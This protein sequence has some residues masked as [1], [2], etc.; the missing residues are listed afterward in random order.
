MDPAVAAAIIKTGGDVLGGLFGGGGQQQPTMEDY[1]QWGEQ[2]GLSNMNQ[3]TA[4]SGGQ[5]GWGN[6]T[7]Y[8]NQQ[9]TNYQN[10]NQA[11]TGGGQNTGFANTLGLQSE[12]GY[13]NQQG[14]S[15]TGGTQ[16]QRGTG[17]QQYQLRGFDPAEQAAYG[18]MTQ[19]MSGLAG[20]LSPEAQAAYG[21]QITESQRQAGLDQVNQE[22]NRQGARQRMAMARTGTG[23]GSVAAEQAAQLAGQ[24]ALAGNQVEATA[25]AAGQNA[26]NQR[27]AA[28]QGA[29]GTMGNAMAGMQGSRQTLG[30]T[31]SFDTTGQSNQTTRNNQQN[32]FGN[33]V[34]N[35]QRTNTGQ[36]Y[37][38]YQNMNQGMQGGYQDFGQSGQQSNY[39]SDYFNNQNVNQQNTNQ[40]YNLFAQ[41]AAQGGYQPGFFD[42]RLAGMGDR[43]AN[44]A[45]PEYGQ[46]P[47]S[48][49]VPPNANY[50]NIP[51]GMTGGMTW[52]PQV[53]QQSPAA[54]Q[55]P[56]HI[57]P[58]QWAAMMAQ[59]GY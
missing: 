44:I 41:D 17:A 1:S 7:G 8:N 48:G 21:Q 31:N 15:A 58:L 52:P 42:S 39:G 9:G 35:D 20:Q 56:D 11:M 10:L 2:G 3:Q 24:K 5:T 37:T 40:A 55:R 25:V 30:T 16:A 6:Q 27:A 34:M 32:Q 49:Y 53:P 47:Q 18:A 45:S 22:F 43:Y 46:P 59:A 29:L 28:N 50:S 51:G 26:M 23:P 57:P 33:T 38:N 12:Q 13:G 36:D 4:G 14:I 19:Q 54:P